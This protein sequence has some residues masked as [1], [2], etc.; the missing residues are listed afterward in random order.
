MNGAALSFAS[1]MTLDKSLRLSELQ[2][3][4]LENGVSSVEVPG[5]PGR[6]DEMEKLKTS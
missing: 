3:S 2:C 6:E 4:H 5:C 1:R